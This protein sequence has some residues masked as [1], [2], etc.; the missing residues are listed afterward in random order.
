MGPVEN[1]GRIQLPFHYLAD[2]PR[3]QREFFLCGHSHANDVQPLVSVHW[4]QYIGFALWSSRIQ[5]SII[6]S[7]TTTLPRA[8]CFDL[9]LECG[10]SH[11]SDVQPLGS[12]HWIRPVVFANPILNYS[13][14]VSP[15]VD[16]SY[17]V[18]PLVLLQGLLPLL[19]VLLSLLVT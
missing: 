9:Q 8:T 16:Y 4:G 18:S 13:Y 19:L 15:L 2:I 12:V 6:F 5:S 10:H 1:G 7:W 17:S 11:A 14:S 3:L